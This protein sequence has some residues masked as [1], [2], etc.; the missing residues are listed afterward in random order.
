MESIFKRKGVA[1]QEKLDNWLE[2]LDDTEAINTEVD[3]LQPKAKKKVN[4]MHTCCDKNK[5]HKTNDGV[6]ASRS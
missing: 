1:R 2:T 6:E 3:L 5:K 4:M